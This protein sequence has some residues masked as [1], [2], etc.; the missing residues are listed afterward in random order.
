MYF[1]I[2]NTRFRMLN[3]FFISVY[4]YLFDSV[5]Y[6]LCY[7]YKK[8]SAIVKFPFRFACDANVFRIVC[9]IIC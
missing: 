2:T 6:S 5:Y 8:K 4:A 9:V 7:A 1:R 3:E